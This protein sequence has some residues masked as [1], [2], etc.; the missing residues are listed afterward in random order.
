LPER[1]N[2]ERGGVPSRARLSYADFEAITGLFGCN[3]AFYDRSRSRCY[4]TLGNG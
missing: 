4:S 1:R 2:Q 3:E